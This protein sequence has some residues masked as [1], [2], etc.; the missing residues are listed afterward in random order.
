LPAFTDKRNGE[1]SCGEAGAEKLGGIWENVERRRRGNKQT[2]A[3]ACDGRLLRLC[4]VHFEE[5][6]LV[7]GPGGALKRV[8]R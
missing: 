7:L 2:F 3:F 8:M 1:P 5:P 4:I 6:V